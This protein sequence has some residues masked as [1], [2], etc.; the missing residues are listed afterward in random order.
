MSADAEQEAGPSSPSAEKDGKRKATNTPPQTG[1]T[2]KRGWKGKMMREAPPAAQPTA[3]PNTHETISTTG[4]F[5]LNKDGN[6]CGLF[7]PELSSYELT[8]HHKDAGTLAE[9]QERGYYYDFL[10]TKSFNRQLYA[11]KKACWFQDAAPKKLYL[12]KEEAAEAWTLL[13]SR[14][15]DAN[16]YGGFIF[17]GCAK[18]NT[19]IDNEEDPVTDDEEPTMANLVAAYAECNITI[20]GFEAITL[21]A[22]PDRLLRGLG[23]LNNFEK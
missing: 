21:K 13:T 6:Y 3:V 23:W 22:E 8:M 9:W 11:T 20:T 18:L 10:A 16:K 2:P 1:E 14:A 7:L 4:L 15:N 5:L 17:Y 19:I 12:N